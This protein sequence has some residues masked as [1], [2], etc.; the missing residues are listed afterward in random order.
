MFGSLQNRSLP[1]LL[2]RPDRLDRR[3]LD[4][5]GRAGIGGGLA[6]AGVLKA[7]T[8]RLVA[9]GLAFAG[10][11]LATAAA[12]SLTF[13]LCGLVVVG[14]ASVAFRAIASCRRGAGEWPRRRR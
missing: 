1:D 9:L 6:L 12:P 4:A 3:H 2:R 5:E 8:N 11:L 14:A 13:A 7:T 10:A